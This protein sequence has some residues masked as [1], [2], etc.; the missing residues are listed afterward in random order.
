[1]LDKIV[2]KEFLIEELEYIKEYPQDYHLEK[3]V[4]DFS[5]YIMIC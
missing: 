1:M 2:L 5:D 4:D 3:M